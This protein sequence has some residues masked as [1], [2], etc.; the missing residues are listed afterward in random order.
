MKARLPHIF[1]VDH[2]TS[3]GEI[4]RRPQVGIYDCDIPEVAISETEKVAS[5]NWLIFRHHRDPN[6]RGACI[7]WNNNLYVPVTSESHDRDL[8]PTVV[9]GKEGVNGRYGVETFVSM[10]R[11][12]ASADQRLWHLCS[13][14]E[15]RRSK[16]SRPKADRIVGSTEAADIETITEMADGL[17]VADNRM[18]QRAV[19][20]HLRVKE[21]GA[22][23]N[24][25]ATEL[26]FDY[27]KDG[28]RTWA[29]D[30]WWNGHRQV[31]IHRASLNDLQQVGALT[32]QVQ[33]PDFSDLEIHDEAALVF[34]GRREYLGR[35]VRELIAAAGVE[36]GGFDAA[37]IGRWLTAREEVLDLLVDQEADPVAPLT[38]LASLSDSPR[39]R[40]SVAQALKSLAVYDDIDMRQTASR[41]QLAPYRP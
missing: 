25:D 32:T 21:V 12:I 10:Y 35:A 13:Y 41:S 38:A 24:L 17:L 33:R 39:L 28:G 1:Y 9:S 3:S 37:K 8:S 15:G 20:L 30:F 18:W 23:R 4:Q 40:D 16:F 5:W 26:Q 22:Q 27:S 31:C 19:G 34:D 6:P 2:L 11:G 29:D 36:V 14:L 7:R